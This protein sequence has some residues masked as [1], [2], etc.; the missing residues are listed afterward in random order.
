MESKERVFRHSVGKLVLMSLGEVLFIFL[1]YFLRTAPYFFAVVLIFVINLFVFFRY[2]V[3]R[4]K[5]SS[6]EII[7]NGL[8]GSKSLRWTEIDHVSARGQSLKLHDRYENITLSL[9]SQLEGYI[10]ILDLIFKKRPDLFDLSED[11]VLSR[12]AINN[13]VVIGFGRMLILFSTFFY[14]MRDQDMIWILTLI[15][16]GLGLYVILSWFL[17][18]QSIALENQALFVKY[19]LKET[20]YKVSDIKNSIILE[21]RKTR[22]GYVYFTQVNPKMVKPLKLSGFKQGSALTYQILKRWHEKAVSKQ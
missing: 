6:E 11:N 3:S 12:T 7:I 4:V 15:F 10:E 17:S 5:I 20:S 14:I 1:A 2:V 8:L 21:K 13:V 22:D 19:L 18:P 16:L 9:V